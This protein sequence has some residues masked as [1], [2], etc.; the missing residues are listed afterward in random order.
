MDPTGY[1][2]EG[3]RIDPAK[4]LL[5]RDNEAVPLMPKA[6]DTLLYLVEHPGKVLEKD[7][8]LSEIWPDA[9]VEENN[10]TQNISVLRK[11]LG[12]KPGEHRFI[13][14]IPGRGYKF[15]A[16]AREVTAEPSAEM[17][18][19]SSKPPTESDLGR[20]FGVEKHGNILAVVDWAQ[21]AAEKTVDDK[22]EAAISARSFSSTP[23]R[24]F[25]YGPVLA[26]GAIIVTVG[27]SLVGF[28]ILNSGQR[29]ADAAGE[30]TFTYLTDGV[31]VVSPAISPDGKYFAFSSFDGEYTHL[32]LQ[33]VGQSTRLEI[34][35]PTRT[36][37]GETTFSPDGQF[38][39]FVG[40]EE[41]GPSPSLYK[42]PAFGKV[43]SKLLDDTNSPV[44]F[45]PDG[46][47]ITFSRRKKDTSESLIVIAKADGSEQRTILT[48][49]NDRFVTYPSWSPDG[50]LIA[51]GNTTIKGEAGT[52]Y[53]NLEAV[54]PEGQGTVLL[55]PEKWA[56]CLRMA[57][58]ANGE[59]IVFVGTKAGETLTT[60]RDQVW[61]VSLADGRSTRISNEG[62][63]H[64]FGGVTRDNAV[65]VQ[66]YDRA[67]Q[68]WAMDANGD[69]RT[70]VQLTSGRSDGRTGIAPLPDGRVGYVAR[71]DDKLELWLVNA[72]G[73]GKTQITNE[74]SQIEELRAS[75][76]GRYFIFLSSINN[77]YQIFRINTDGS[78]LKQLTFELDT[79]AADASISPDG[80]SIVYLAEKAGGGAW[81][82]GMSI[83]G[84]PVAAITSKDI[85]AGTPHYSPDGRLISF[86]AENGAK[87]AVIGADGGQIRFFETVKNARLN[88]GARWT[89]ESSSLAYIVY[90]NNVSNIWLQ[91][92]NGDPPHPLTNFTSGDNL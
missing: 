60:R 15:V 69:S 47:A 9:I 20:R 5:L 50:K 25:R 3:F 92:V 13:V 46:S 17:P 32:W 43:F 35:E 84:G 54:D 77:I 14:T 82:Q 18:A 6:F 44:S 4:R 51:F 52:P 7:L 86:V 19:E 40:S 64:E 2:F 49:G 71:H 11:A 65:L 88:V 76:D 78:D 74:P 85:R 59:G 10:L 72:D 90:R 58:T 91:P 79:H 21:P 63:R 75:A 36:S 34:I 70:A 12:E 41:N 80:R 55:S 27:L 67:A 53:C 73:S 16:P 33:Q 66:P 42:L 30:R 48:N 61:Y 68:I 81:L 87:I 62:F 22:G 26:I 89:P 57:W 83:D 28:W 31:E 56:N 38:I 23:T 24:R 37:V 8:L 39:Y 1:E 45:S 29:D